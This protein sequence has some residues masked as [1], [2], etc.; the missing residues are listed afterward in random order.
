MEYFY[1]LYTC[2]LLNFSEPMHQATA[3]EY[4]L[5]ACI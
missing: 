3:I 2:D 4:Y 1:Y 5:V